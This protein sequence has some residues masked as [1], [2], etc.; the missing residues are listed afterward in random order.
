MELLNSLSALLWGWPTIILLLGTGIYFTISLKGLQFVRLGYAFKMIFKKS[1]KVAQGDISHF[2]ALMTALS[3]TVGTGNIAGVATAI[4]VGG[5]GALFWMWITGLV[6]MVTK[7]AEALLAVHYREKDSKGEMCGGPMYYIEKGLGFK[8]LAQLFALFTAIA[9]F[10]IGNTVQS[11][12]VARSLQASFNIDP[13]ITGIILAF[14]VAAV[15]VGGIHSIARVV[16]FIVPIMI[17]F[18]FIGAIWIV[19]SHISALPAVLMMVIKYAFTP[20]AASGGL[21]GTTI[22]YGIARGI[23]SNESGMGSAPIAAAAARTSSPVTQALVSMTQTFIDTII[24]CSLTGFSILLTGALQF[25]DNGAELTMKAF[26]LGFMNSYG[27]IFVSIAVVL[28][29]FSTLV[30][31]NYYGEKAVEYLW[32]LKMVVPYKMV[33]T[34]FVFIG[35]ISTLNLVWTFADVANALMILPNLIALIWLRKTVKQLTRTYFK[36]S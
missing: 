35:A 9:A 27:S 31:W 19:L 7:Y 2:Q 11:N 22:R 26:D 16:S 25:G 34:A 32:G 6:G 21:I 10:G 30:G 8:W 4:F 33:Y 29:A 1:E 23:F 12:T 3:A 13:T 18:Y 36:D 15:I 28:F 17:I 14:L 20:Q 24:V 5:P